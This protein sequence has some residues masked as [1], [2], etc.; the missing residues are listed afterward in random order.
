MSQATINSRFVESICFDADFNAL[1]E[2]HRSATKGNDGSGSLSRRHLLRL[3]GFSRV[4]SRCHKNYMDRISGTALLALKP[5]ALAA[6]IEVF[7][8][9]GN[10]SAI[11]RHAV[12]SLFPWG[13][14]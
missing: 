9:T 3:Q 12:H 5:G 8:D 11:A 4:A 2:A 7:S 1:A 13:K 10:L 14:P 6:N